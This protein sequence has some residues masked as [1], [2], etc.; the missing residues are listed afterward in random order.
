MNGWIWS[1]VFHTRD[2]PFTEFLDYTSAY[3]IV[4]S[5]LYCF[6]MRMCHR[7]S[8][9]FKGVITVFFVSFYLNYFHY[10]S[11]GKFS[12]SFN[13]KTNVVTGLF[14][15]FHKPTVTLVS[16]RTT[17]WIGMDGMVFLG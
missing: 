13:M 17:I 8:L 3:L 11:V 16:Y 15:D 14:P 4:L 12:Y 5:V 7:M 2:S 6:C 9:P 1:T 10:L